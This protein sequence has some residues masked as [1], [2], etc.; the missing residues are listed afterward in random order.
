MIEVA[1]RKTLR[2][3]TLDV[4]T[5]F[6]VGVTVLAGP[7]GS[8]KSTLL[9]IIA[10]LVEPDSGTV[11]LAGRALRDHGTSVPAF[12]RGIAFVFQEYALFPHLDVIDNV[13]YGLA[14]RGV[15]RAQRRESARIW[16][17]RLGIARLAGARPRALSGGERQRVALAR[18]L[19]WTPSAV[20]LDEPF[21]ALDELTR[22]LVRDELRATLAAL[23]VPVV[24]VTHDE[25]DAKLF[26]ARVVRLDRG[27]LAGD[28]PARSAGV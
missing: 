18:A 1:V 4:A 22:A 10:G 11:A 24:L 15:P 8:G 3:F 26:A 17:E 23:D 5:H 9:R 16:L 2:H 12:R 20:L 19:A 28:D 25:A 13:A 14:A 6:G 27:R 7:S 21:A